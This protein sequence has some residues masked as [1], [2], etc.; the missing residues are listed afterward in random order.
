MTN[1]QT[2][3]LVKKNTSRLKYFLQILK[4]LELAYKLSPGLSKSEIQ[5][6][7]KVFLNIFQKKT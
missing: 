3:E 2:S 5:S 7:I 4:E 6:L 1:T